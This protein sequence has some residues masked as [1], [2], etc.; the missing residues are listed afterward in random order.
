MQ[1]PAAAKQANWFSASLARGLSVICAFGADSPRLR[2][3]EIAQRANLTRAAARRYLLTLAELGYVGR[4]GDQFFLRPRVLE[5]GFAYVSSVR[6]EETVEPILKSLSERTGASAHVALLDN[7]TALFVATV[8]SDK[9][10]GYFSTVG[11]RRPA[12]AGSLGKVLLSGLSDE[13]LNAYLNKAEL[14]RH[15]P[16]TIANAGRLRD[17]LERVREQGYALNQGEY[18]P[19]IMGL[20]VPVRDHSGIVVAALNV[21]WLSSAPIQPAEINRILP[22]LKSAAADMET[23]ILKGRLSLA[24]PVTAGPSKE[25]GDRF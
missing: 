10:H 13:Q 4:D 11:T 24:A 22:L 20:A 8:Y 1:D 9:M 7:D 12:Y 16:V 23:L 17:E 25:S 18:I 5:L 6:I 2:I 15:T 3:S 14:Q 19:G 21:N